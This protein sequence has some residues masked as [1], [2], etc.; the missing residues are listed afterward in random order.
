MGATIQLCGTSGAFFIPGYYPQGTFPSDIS[1]VNWPQLDY[2]LG[3]I[4]GVSEEEKQ[5][6]LRGAMQLAYSLLYWMQTEAPRHD[7]KGVG[8]PG[9]RLRPD[10]VGTEH[11]LAKYVYVREARRIQAEFTVLEQHVVVEARGKGGTAGAEVFD[12]SVGIGYYRID[13]HPSTGLRNY[14]DLSSFP[15]QIPLGRA[16]SE[17][18][19]ESAACRQ[20][21]R[22]DAHHQRLLS[23]APDRVEYRR[24]GGRTG[25]LLFGAPSD[26][27]PGTQRS[28]NICAISSRCSRTS[29][30]SRWNGPGMCGASISPAGSIR[31]RLTSIP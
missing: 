6:N 16:D 9:L 15:F 4:V 31:T 10:V 26:A 22:H 20:E 14:V 2:W 27:A 7:D 23:S 8:Y 17:T 21:H 1:L 5:K 29:S 28:R 3:P 13:L 19:R 25:G 11:G 30:A 12:D 18:G 24:S